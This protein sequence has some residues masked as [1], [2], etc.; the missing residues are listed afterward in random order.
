MIVFLAWKTWAMSLQIQ[1]CRFWTLTF[2]RDGAFCLA[3]CNVV[4]LIHRDLEIHRNL[5]PRMDDACLVLVT[6]LV[7]VLV[8]VKPG[9][10]I[11]Q[12]SAETAQVGPVCKR[13][14]DARMQVRWYQANS[15]T[16]RPSPARHPI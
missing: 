4:R 7:L 10:G 9:P 12:D 6:V 8:L 2:A 11:C 1:D 13:V 16:S 3:F 15:H 5:L 14:L